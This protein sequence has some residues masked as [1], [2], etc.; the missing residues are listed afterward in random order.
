MKLLTSFL[1]V[2]IISTLVAY[3]SFQQ[4]FVVGTVTDAIT[5]NPL[6]GVNVLIEGT[7]TGASTDL[8]GKFSLPKPQ[9][10]AVITISFIGYVT[11]KVTLSGQ[12]VIDIKLS[13]TVLAL[14]EVVVTGYGTIKKKDLTGAISSVSSKDIEKTKPVNIESA[15]EGRVPGVT[16]T[17][18][19]GAPGS[20]AIIRIRGIGTVNNNSPIYVVDGMLINNSD[21]NDPTTNI[22]FLNPADISSIE[23]LKDASS[24]AIYG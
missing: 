8:N 2:L 7:K 5:G 3:S 16:V 6:P 4:Q 13:P 11:E 19:S 12:T 14:E 23:V 20:G 9:N 21:Q 18:N 22:Q 17:A 15:L 1:F 24:Q 10:G